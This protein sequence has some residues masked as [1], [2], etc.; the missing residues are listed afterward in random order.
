MVLLTAKQSS[1]IVQ[2]NE[3]TAVKRYS[4]QPL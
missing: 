1:D 2:K 3:K 4:Q